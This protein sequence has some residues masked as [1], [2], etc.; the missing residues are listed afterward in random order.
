[1]DVVVSAV[2]ALCFPFSCSEY[3]FGVD[4]LRF[5]LPSGMFSSDVGY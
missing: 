4:S 2:C 1:M 5:F 3:I